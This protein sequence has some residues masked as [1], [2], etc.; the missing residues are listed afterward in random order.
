M[1][2]TMFFESCFI[3]TIGKFYLV[4]VDVAG[5]GY[6]VLSIKQLHVMGQW[7]LVTQLHDFVFLEYIS[8]NIFLLCVGGYFL[9]R[10]AIHE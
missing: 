3:Y 8:G 7:L 4:F 10:L 5:D 1:I 2:C 6:L 9:V